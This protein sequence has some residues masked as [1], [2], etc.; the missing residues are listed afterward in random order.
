MDSRLNLAMIESHEAELRRRA[1]EGRVWREWPD[2]GLPPNP[3]HGRRP[4]HVALHPTAV[5]A[6]LLTTR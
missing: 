2:D 5:L 1:N 4:R 3:P 6:A